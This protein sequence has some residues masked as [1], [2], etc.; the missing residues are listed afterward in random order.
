M[1]KS[2]RDR[3]FV[4]VLLAYCI[5]ISIVYLAVFGSVRSYPDL[6]DPDSQLWRFYPAWLKPTDV[7]FFGSGRTIILLLLPVGVLIAWLAWQVLG[8]VAA[9]YVL[10]PYHKGS[11]LARLAPNRFEQR[12]SQ[13]YLVAGDST[14]KKNL[15]SLVEASVLPFSLLLSASIMLMTQRLLLFPSFVAAPPFSMVVMILMPCT[16]FINLALYI[17]LP[18]IGLATTSIWILE[19]SGLRYYDSERKTIV[20]VAAGYKVTLDSFS[21]ISAV[22]SFLSLLYDIMVSRGLGFDYVL[23]ELSLIVLL[24]YPPTLLVTALYIHLSEAQSVEKVLEKMRNTGFPLPEVP[25]IDIK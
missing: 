5:S 4:A 20:E 23:S 8:Y 24:L 18:L 10:I 7:Y 2:P 9:S 25:P 14:H 21:G 13:K 16:K 19:G 15:K 12:S 3:G 17:V 6:Y 1:K 22:I 11:I